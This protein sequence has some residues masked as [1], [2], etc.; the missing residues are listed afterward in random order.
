MAQVRLLPVE[1]TTPVAPMLVAQRGDVRVEFAV[2]T[3][4]A[5]V[6]A[7]LAALRC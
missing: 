1:V 7:V 5:Y 6:A 3:D 2:G 4:P